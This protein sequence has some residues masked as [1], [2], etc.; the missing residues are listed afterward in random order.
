MSDGTDDDDGGV[1][2]DTPPVGPPPKGP[3]RGTKD[4]VSRLMRAGEDAARDELT[5]IMNHVRYGHF[6]DLEPPLHVDTYQK[7]LNLSMLRRFFS[8]DLDEIAARL[9]ATQDELDE[10]LTHEHYAAVERA[11]IE[12]AKAVNGADTIDKVAELA[13]PRVAKKYL[14]E[15]FSGHNVREQMRAVDAM[16]DRRAP[17]PS[18]RAGEGAAPM[19]FPADML[20]VMQLAMEAGRRQG[21][22]Q[23]QGQQ[24][25]LPPGAP[26]HLVT[27][28]V[29]PTD[30]E[31]D[32]TV[33]A[34]VLNVPGARRAQG[35]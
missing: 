24:A 34:E 8:F 20:A 26:D 25:A 30:P 11:V 2:A 19:M 15:A 27:S 5:V 23:G 12:A 13:E 7:L 22:G 1:M 4:A 31:N 33:D 10:L 6:I 21:Q 29:V 18:R 3:L 14:L 35:M 17:K 32:D 28:S 9:H 16:A